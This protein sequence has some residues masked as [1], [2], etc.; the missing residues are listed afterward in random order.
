MEADPVNAQTFRNNED[1]FRFI[2]ISHFGLDI[3]AAAASGD[4]LRIAEVQRLLDGLAEIYRMGFEDGERL[5]IIVDYPV[6]DLV[7]ELR[8]D[9]LLA[10]HRGD[11][12]LRAHVFAEI[13]RRAGTGNDPLV[14]FAPPPAEQD[15]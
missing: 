12:D 10:I 2:A 3:D 9:F 11:A 6:P 13:A 8:T 1:P 14:A 5:A 15:G 4:A 7:A